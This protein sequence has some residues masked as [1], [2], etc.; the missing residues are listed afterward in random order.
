[1]KNVKIWFNII[2]MTL[3]VVSIGYS[4]YRSLSNPETRLDTSAKINHVVTDGLEFYYP[5]QSS[6]R[7]HSGK[8]KPD[9]LKFPGTALTS[10][11]GTRGIE[12]GDSSEY[13]EIENS[14]KNIKSDSSSS[15]KLVFS[16][17]N[18]PYIIIFIISDLHYL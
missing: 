14:S 12:L 4:T 16:I 3:L 9:L 11:G 17:I 18:Y 6:F 8:N 7:D 10:Y 15:L 13:F 1:M 5:L 2:I